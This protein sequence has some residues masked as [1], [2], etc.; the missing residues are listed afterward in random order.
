MIALVVT[1][2]FAGLAFAYVK[3]RRQRKGAA[4]QAQ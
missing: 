4:G 1:I 2:A 3:I